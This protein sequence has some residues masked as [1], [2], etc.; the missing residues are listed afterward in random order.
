MA[1]KRKTLKAKL[2]LLSALPVLATGF[3]LAVVCYYS[4]PIFNLAI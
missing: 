2:T 4:Q 1:K 3:V